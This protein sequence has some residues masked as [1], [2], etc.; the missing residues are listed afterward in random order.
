MNYHWKGL[1]K[2]VMQKR[3]TLLTIS[4]AEN[5]SNLV[6]SAMVYNVML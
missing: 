3:D 4:V 5:T 6:V 1:Q 2:P